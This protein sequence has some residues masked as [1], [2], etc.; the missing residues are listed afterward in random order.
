MRLAGVSRASCYY[1]RVLLLLPS[2]SL[3][4]LLTEFVQESFNKSNLGAARSICVRGR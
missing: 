2:S 4:Y 3:D 1:P